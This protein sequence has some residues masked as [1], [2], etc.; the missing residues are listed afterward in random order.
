[1]LQLCVQQQE[2]KSSVSTGVAGSEKWQ[3]LSLFLV[4]LLE[5]PVLGT[6]FFSVY[7]LGLCEKERDVDFRGCILYI[8]FCLYVKVLPKLSRQQGTIKT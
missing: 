1:M 8:K 3:K 6:S 2:A 7:S 5:W 4:L